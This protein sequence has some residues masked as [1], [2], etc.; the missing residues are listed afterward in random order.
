MFA[1]DA[2]LVTSTSGIF[3]AKMH[4]ISQKTKQKL[5]EWKSQSWTMHFC[6][7]PTQSAGTGKPSSSYHILIQQ[8]DEKCSFE[9]LFTRYNLKCSHTAKLL[10]SMN[11]FSCETLRIIWFFCEQKLLSLIW[12]LHFH[13][14]SVFQCYMYASLRLLDLYHNS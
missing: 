12:C 10:I 14:F 8:Q 7:S 5:I 6:V 9:S 3:L 4:I 1:F 13:W 2:P 11:Y